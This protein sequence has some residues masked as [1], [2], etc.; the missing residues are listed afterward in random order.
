MRIFWKTA[1]SPPFG[2]VWTTLSAFL[3]DSPK[4]IG[5]LSLSPILQLGKFFLLSIAFVTAKPVISEYWICTAKPPVLKIRFLQR[6]LNTPLSVWSLRIRYT[7]AC[8]C[9]QH[10]FVNYVTQTTLL[11]FI[12]S[13][14]ARLPTSRIRH[15][16]TGSRCWNRWTAVE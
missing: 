4:S 11:Y 3:R 7:H 1:F 2:V 14:T 13:A 6:Y 10:E 9:L 12:V 16:W 15:E 5:S 8:S